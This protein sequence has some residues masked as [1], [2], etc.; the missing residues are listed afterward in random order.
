MVGTA[1]K[2]KGGRIALYVFV[3]VVCINTLSP[4]FVMFTTAAKTND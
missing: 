3:V 2:T 1:K 4:Y